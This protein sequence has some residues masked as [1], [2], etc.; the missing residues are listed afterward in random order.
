METVNELYYG[1]KNKMPEVFLENC[2]NNLSFNELYYGNKM[3]E[4]KKLFN[5]LWMET[6]NKMPEVFV[7]N[8]FNNLS[9]DD[10]M[11]KPMIP[12]YEKPGGPNPPT[13]KK[14]FF[15]KFEKNLW[16]KYGEYFEQ[17]MGASHPMRGHKDV[18]LMKVCTII[19]KF[20]KIFRHNLRL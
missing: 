12:N 3:P 5:I 20:L 11:A 18:K 14:I 4:D 2:F 9:V 15:N 1:N 16:S 19:T 8:C 13:S 10:W 17:Q 6:F 7:E